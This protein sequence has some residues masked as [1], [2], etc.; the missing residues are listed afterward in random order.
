MEDGISSQVGRR[1]RM[2]ERPPRGVKPGKSPRI[3]TRT[4]HS[5]R[6]YNYWLGGKDNFPADREA[7]EA[8]IAANPQIVADVRANRAFLARVVR[9]LV[10]EAGVRQFLD[11]GTGLPTASNT[12]EV[13]QAA[14]PESRVVY[15]DN[16]PIVLAHARALLTSTPEGVTAYL[17]A[18]LR[19]PEPI[20]RSAARTLDLSQPVALMLLIILHLI[21]DREEPGKIVTRLMSALAPGSYLVLA[22]PASDIQP[23]AMAEMTRRVNQRMRGAVATLRTHDQVVSFF[24]GLELLPPGVVQPQQWRPGPAAPAPAEVTAWS[25]VARKS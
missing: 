14:A 24:D 25:G 6:V 21:Q 8:A 3:D 10:T 22:H 23:A 20:L 13:A 5:A 1:H 9:Y 16:D 7:A 15:V 4:A 12:H 11:I 17:D 2:T 19:E 18:D